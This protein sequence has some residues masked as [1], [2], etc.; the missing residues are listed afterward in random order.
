MTAKQ[1]SPTG[2]MGLCLSPLLVVCGVA[3]ASVPDAC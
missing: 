3:A 2:K 1:M